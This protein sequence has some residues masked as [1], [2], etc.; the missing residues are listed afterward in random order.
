MG[1]GLFTPCLQRDLRLPESQQEQGCSS[2]PS[3]ES[4]E[5]LSLPGQRLIPTAH[6]ASV[7]APSCLQMRKGAGLCDRSLLTAWSWKHPGQ[8]LTYFLLPELE[9]FM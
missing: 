3:P 4:Q 6:T 1:Q 5:T 7:L 8:A 2:G 9:T